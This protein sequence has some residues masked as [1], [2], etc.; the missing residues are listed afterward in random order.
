MLRQEANLLHPYNVHLI[1]TKFFL[2]H[3]AMELSRYDEAL[4]LYQQ[5]LP[6]LKFYVHANHPTIAVNKIGV[7]NLLEKKKKW[8]EAKQ[9]FTEAL[10]IMEHSHGSTHP[11]RASVMEHI[12]SCDRHLNGSGQL[13]DTG[14]TSDAS[15]SS[16]D[17]STETSSS[18]EPNSST[19]TS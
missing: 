14:D 6:C 9:N 16:H 5:L 18:S 19:E 17:D 1:R 15:S 8:T 7:G 10:A 11:L 3:A 2:A 4:D 12:S 13:E